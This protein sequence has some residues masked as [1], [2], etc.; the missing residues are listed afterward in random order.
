MKILLLEPNRLLAEQYMRYLE[1][2]G[3]ELIWCENAQDGVAAADELRPNLIIVELLLAGHSGVEFLYEFRSYADWLNLPVIILSG[4]SQLSAGVSDATLS[5]L[6]VGAYLYKP[7][8][9]LDQLGRSIRRVLGIKQK[10]K[11]RHE[12]A[13]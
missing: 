7:E 13:K 11:K 1:K 6:G 10:V 5:E 8:T 4:I 9:S 2:E 3:Y 12:A